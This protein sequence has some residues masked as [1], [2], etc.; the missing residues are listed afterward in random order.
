M[1]PRARSWRCAFSCACIQIEDK[2]LEAARAEELHNEAKSLFSAAS[3]AE[4]EAR[5]R[6]E[7]ELARRTEAEKVLL[8]QLEEVRGVLAGRASLLCIFVLR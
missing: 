4:A 5:T 3:L 6:A 8:Q 7:A 2:K 1:R